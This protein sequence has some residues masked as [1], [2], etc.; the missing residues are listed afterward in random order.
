MVNSIQNGSLMAY[1]LQ[2]IADSL[3]LVTY[4]HQQEKSIVKQQPNPHKPTLYLIHTQN[5]KEI[6]YA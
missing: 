5:L 4:S 3:Q 6:T 1:R 2:L